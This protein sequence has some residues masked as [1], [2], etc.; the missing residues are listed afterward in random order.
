M[1]ILYVLNGTFLRGGTEAVILNY[2]SHMNRKKIQI[3]F[4]LHTT[5]EEMQSN[6]ICQSLIQEGANIYCVTPRYAGVK[7]NKQDITKVLMENQF[8]AIHTHTDAIGSYILAIAKKCGIPVRIAH[9]HNTEVPVKPNTFKNILHWLYL[10]GCHYSIRRQA[11]H[12]MAC[13]QKAG[14]WLFG[15]KAWKEGKVY[16]LRNGIDLQKYAYN[17]STRERIK[18]EMNL[19]GKVVLGHVGRFAYQKN[20]DFIIDVFAQVHKENNNTVLLL[21]GEGEL[22]S[23][24]E[25]KV[26]Q[27]GLENAVIFYGVSDH[28]EDLL[29]V[30][31]IFVFPS[32]WEGLGM[33]LVEAQASGLMCFAPDIDKVSKD[34]QMTDLIRFLPYDISSW[35][36]EINTVIANL[37]HNERTS[38]I[39]MVN[40]K[41]NRYDI[42]EEALCLEKYYL[43]LL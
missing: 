43:S 4:M 37:S 24:I 35:A 38:D 42:Y 28:V 13:S 19:E 6:E 5:E 32:R 36:K 10:E 2:F 14:E 12:Y 39:S 41:E 30:M 40:I 31:D 15:K 7:Q 27:L 21:V 34:S 29:Q 23:E 33:V 17:S 1:R 16:Y 25:E 8:D 18:K 22:K 9:S 20:H 26:R 11:T 3:D